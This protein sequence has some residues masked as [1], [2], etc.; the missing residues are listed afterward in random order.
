[1]LVMIYVGITIGSVVLKNVPLKECAF[2]SACLSLSSTPLVMKF[3]QSNE[4]SRVSY[5]HTEINLY[6]TV[7]LYLA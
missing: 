2:I 6:Q 7:M 4:K 5:F 1:M 3:L